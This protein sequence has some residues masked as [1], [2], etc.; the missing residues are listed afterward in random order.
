MRRGV[1]ARS[2]NVLTAMV[3]HQ[4]NRRRRNFLEFYLS[5][6]LNETLTLTCS[7]ESNL[8][9]CHE[10]RAANF[11][12]SFTHL[13]TLKTDTPLRLLLPLTFDT[14]A[15]NNSYSWQVNWGFSAGLL[16]WVRLGPFYHTTYPVMDVHSS[17]TVLSEASGLESLTLHLAELFSFTLMLPLG[18]G[19]SGRM[20]WSARLLLTISWKASIQ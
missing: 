18:S 4:A 16:L 15:Y 3:K 5:P 6:F 19:A 7:S 14:T 10:W 20:C 12:Q 8:L 9:L 17:K 13:F 1:F 2:T 11:L